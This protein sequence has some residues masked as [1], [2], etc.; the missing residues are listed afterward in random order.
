MTWLRVVVLAVVALVLSALSSASADP[1]PDPKIQ[2]EA[3]FMTPT[4]IM[5]F[6]DFVCQEG[7][8]AGIGVGANQP[9]IGAPDTNGFGFT[10]LEATGQRQTAEVVVRSFQGEWR[11]GDASANAQ[12][13]CGQG[14]FGRDSAEIVIEP[15]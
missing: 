11:L 5:V 1:I 6:V 12:V 9:T 3:T 4:Q 2:R 15:F 14:A 8:D 13:S 10:S 7:T